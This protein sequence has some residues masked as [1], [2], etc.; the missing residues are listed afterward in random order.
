MRTRLLNTALVIA[1]LLVGLVLIEIGLRLFSPFEMRLIDSRI[2]LPY[3]KRYEIVTEGARKLEPRT[4]HT[5]NA[6]GLR[7]PNPPRDFAE[8][9][10]LVAVGG[11]TTECFVLGD[12]KDWPAVVGRRL[13]DSL[14]K[15][16][17]NNAGLNGHTT[18]GHSELL[19]QHL[20]LLE[21]DVLLFLTGV[22][23]IPFEDNTARF[24]TRLFTERAGAEGLFWRWRRRA[25]RASHLAALALNI[26]RAART[27]HEGFGD[28]TEFDYASFPTVEVTEAEIEAVLA[29]HR[30]K[31]FNGYAGRIEIL[32]ELIR[33]HGIVPVF[34]TQPTL[35]G[36]DPD[37]ATGVDLSRIDAGFGGGSLGTASSRPITRCSRTQA[38]G[39]GS[40]SSTWRPNCRNRARSTTT[41]STSRTWGRSA[42]ARSSRPR[43]VPISGSAFPSTGAGPAPAEE[44][45][46]PHWSDLI[47]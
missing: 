40:W 23:E 7:G 42:S 22:N 1:S 24:D 3:Y 30:A 5:R 29:K 16:W 27:A 18:F 39:T 13:G 35:M 2:N 46:I 45:R 17:A 25:A 12:G 15:V 9:L 28:R 20:L 31:N 10:T 47:L 26:Y 33:A 21:P 44:T 11:S 6:L 36:P 8:H 4:V 41:S 38:P 14:D 32:I 34:V 19:K 37:P 43:C